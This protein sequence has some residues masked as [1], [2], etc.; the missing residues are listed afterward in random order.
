MAALPW[1]KWGT[2]FV[3]LDNDG[4][5]DLITAN[6]HVY[7]QVDKIPTDP[8][9]WQPTILNMNLGNGKLCDASEEAGPAIEESAWDA[10]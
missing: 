3:D 10:D 8:G 4:W 2:A 7:P 5:L 9:Y 1:V 6:G